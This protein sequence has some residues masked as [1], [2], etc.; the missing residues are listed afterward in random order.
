[1]VNGQRWQHQEFHSRNI[2]KS[3]YFPTVDSSELLRRSW[4]DAAD[5]VNF[6]IALAKPKLSQFISHTSDPSSCRVFSCN[7][8]CVVGEAF[9]ISYDEGVGGVFCYNPQLIQWCCQ[10]LRSKRAGC[11][12]SCWH[13]EYHSHWFGSL[14]STKPKHKDQ[15]R[16]QANG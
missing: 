1:M 6:Y 14:A 4:A 5:V 12:Q 2:G 8:E 3:L 16:I 15:K 9:Q 7:L 11:T 13:S 10:M